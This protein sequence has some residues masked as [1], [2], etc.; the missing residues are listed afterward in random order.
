LGRPVPVRTLFDAPTVAALAAHLDDRPTAVDEP[1]PETTL[2]PVAGPRPDHIPLSPAQQRLWFINQFDPTSAAYNLPLAIRLSGHLSPAALGAALHDLLARHESLRTVYPA[3]AAGP[4]QR[5]LDAAD[6]PLPLDVVP[7]GEDT[8]H[9]AI[10]EFLGAGFDVT[11]D[12][13]VRA[14]VFSFGRE[15]HLAVLV[16]HHIAADGGSTGPLARDLVLAYAA[17]SRGETPT[18]PPLPVQ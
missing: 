7:A 11:V 2:G 9:T 17:R 6:V 14:R 16:V 8:V 13:P 1:A 18:F 10:G 15:D 12:I 5:I 4:H 3:S